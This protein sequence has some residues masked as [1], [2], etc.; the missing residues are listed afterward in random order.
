MFI[1]A[2]II[3]WTGLLSAS[4]VPKIKKKL[5]N[6]NPYRT[7]KTSMAA[8]RI[9]Y[10]G[11]D[12]II[13]FKYS[14][15]LTIAFI[16]MMYGMGMPSLFPIAA[17]NLWNQYVAERIVV[18][19]HMKAPAALDDKLT[20]NCI[21]KLRFAPMLFLINGAWMLGN[22]QMFTNTWSYIEDSSQTMRSDHYTAWKLD[23][24]TPEILFGLLSIGLY[25]IQKIFGDKLAEWGFGMA[26]TEIAVD[27]DL[28]NFFKSVKLSQADE[29]IAE[30][31]N[32][33]Q[34]YGFEPNDPD[35][36]KVLDS[37]V[38]PKK[39]IQGTPWYQILSNFNYANDFN[40]IGANVAE[41]EKLIEDGYPEVFENGVKSQGMTLACKKARFEQSDMVVLLL[42]ISYV[43]D[44][45]ARK[46]NF[47]PGWSREFKKDMDE[48]K[49]NFYQ[50]FE[51]N[52]EF[53]NS[54][55]EDD[56]I[57][58]FRAQ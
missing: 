52:W 24:N 58:F 2:V 28:P 26:D 1:Q 33:M 20:V 40:Y 25:I 48:Y 27:E 45:V 14:G 12:Y 49:R 54:R 53:Q 38:V 44:E 8:L 31:T 18:A 9:L 34:N 50:K 56:Y 17:L 30:N 47:K 32:M 7:K 43:P 4:L 5:D 19:Y 36:I 46:I 29:L 16:T 10:S 41:R 22:T 3:P 35:T 23:W 37:T 21:S 6:G 57:D 11:G 42:N 13:H 51:R 15:M 55:L 39:A